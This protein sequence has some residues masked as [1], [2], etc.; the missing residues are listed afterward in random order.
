MAVTI[1]DVARKLK[2]SISTVSR[3]LDGY[4]DVAERTRQRVLEAARQMG[5]SPNQAARQLRRQRVETLGFILPTDKPRFS[6]PFYAEF[7]AG[8]SDEAAVQGYDLMVTTVP[9]DTEAEQRSYERWTHGHKVAGLALNR[10]RLK[11]WRA[12]YLSQIGFPFVTLERSLDPIEYASVEVNGQ[13]WFQ[14]LVDHLVSLGH[15]RIAY[16]GA[17]PK[18]K[19]QADRFDGY[20]SGLKSHGLPFDPQLVAEGD[21]TSESGYQAANLLLSLP[22]PPT[23]I[24]CINDLTAIG[25]LHAA[26]QFN[27]QVGKDLAVTGFDGIASAEHTQ[28]PLTTVNQP[29][30]HIARRMVE[31]LATLVANGS[32]KD[33]HVQIEPVLEIRESTTGETR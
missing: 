31:M 12:Q 8:L 10:L 19:I 7:I 32:V 18:L 29:V 30:Y 14:V 11:D 27:R 22:D 15:S 4:D 23:A 2:L 16:I 33:L 24:T 9:P 6:D 5:Y 17:S 1:R 26:R 28:P 25:V 21:L 13:R 3:A 20:R